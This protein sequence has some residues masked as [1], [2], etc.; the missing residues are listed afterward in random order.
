M[1]NKKQ[2]DGM[3]D[4]PVKK[5]LKWHLPTDPIKRKKV[6]IILG[7]I[8]AILL[9]A[10]IALGLQ[11]KNV[12]SNGFSA[13][14]T[15]GIADKL[16]GKVAVSDLDGVEYDSSLAN[17]R[18]LAIMVENHPEARPQ[19]GLTRASIVYEAVAE[20]G[21]TRY[22]AVFGAKD[23]DKVGPIRSAR[24]YYVEWML[25]YDA[26]YAHAGGAQNAL[27]LLAQ[28]R[29]GEGNIDQAG[30][31]VMWR[32]RRGNEASEHTLYGSTVFMRR[33]SE[34]VSWH[35]DASYTPWKFA[36]DKSSEGERAQNPVAAIHIPY[37]GSYKVDF[38]YDATDN[39]W[40]RSLANNK[41][42]DAETNEQISPTNVIVMTVNRTEVMSSGKQVGQLDLYGS[43]KALI[44]MGGKVTEGTWEKE[45]Q[46]KRTRFFDKD[47]H[48]ITLIPG[49]TWIS[50]VQ[51]GIVA[52]YDQKTTTETAN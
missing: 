35:Q 43:G 33:Y 51:P 49:Q 15:T 48:E 28:L 1:D 11:L 37:G 27:D 9:G 12:D 5:S 38:T 45:G 18:P 6:L 16:T 30:K 22:L 14:D 40:R 24:T 19:F 29:K 44:F 23:S 34:D 4:V 7:V 13:L 21:I 47:D 50:I 8:G 31:P 36:A 32:D 25:E 2:T 3:V 20:G 41:D 39:V 46:T 17:R 52:T 42:I 26:I 10:I